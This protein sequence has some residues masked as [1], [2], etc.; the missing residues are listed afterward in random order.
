MPRQTDPLAYW[1]LHAMKYPVLSKV[2]PRYLSIPT[3]SAP[4]ER[5]FSVTGKIFRPERCRLSS[6]VLEKLMFIRG[7]A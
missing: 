1:K 2:A 6:E 5:V 3:S 7:N 4:T